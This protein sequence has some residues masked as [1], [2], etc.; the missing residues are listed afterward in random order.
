MQPDE[1]AVPDA[2]VVLEVCE[3]DVRARHGQVG[4]HEKEQDC[5]NAHKNQR[6]VLLQCAAHG[7]FAVIDH[8]LLRSFLQVTHSFSLGPDRNMYFPE[9]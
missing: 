9:F 6:P 7:R 3:G 4:K 2:L 8:L 5:R 1:G